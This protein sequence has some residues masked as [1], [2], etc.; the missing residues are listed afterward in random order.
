MEERIIEDEIGKRIRFKRGVDGKVEIV[1]DF[2]SGDAGDE[3]GD[4]DYI[5]LGDEDN[6]E[7]SKLSETT[8]P[9][10]T[11]KDRLSF[12]NILNKKK[13]ADTDSTVE[14]A[15]NENTNDNGEL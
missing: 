1:D 7:L 9:R 14:K 5:E 6:E 12:L 3:V 15:D 11:L 8:A 2:L 10:K 13:A 4:Y